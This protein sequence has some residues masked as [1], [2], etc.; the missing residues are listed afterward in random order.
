[1]PRPR[2][3]VSGLLA[4]WALVAGGSP[5]PSARA[6]ARVDFPGLVRSGF[7]F[8][9]APFPECHASTIA[10]T[11]GGLV[12]AWFG[13]TAEGNPDVGIWLARLDGN[14]WSSP[15]A[16]ARGEADGN[17]SPCWNPVLFQPVG[18]PLLLFYKVGP[19]P[20]DWWGMVTTSDDGGQTWAAP[21]RLPDGI[22]GPIKNKPIARPDDAILC[23]SSTEDQGWRVHFETTRDLGR[24][25]TRTPPVAGNGFNAIQPSILTHGD[26]TLQALCRTREQRLVTTWSTDGG[27]T[28]SALRATTLPNPNSGTDA[29]TLADGRQLLVYNHT[30][31]GRSPLN[32]AIAADGRDWQAALVLEDEP[33]EYSYPAVIQTAD[34]LVQI[35][36]TW[37]RRR[38]RHVVVDP[39]RLVPQPIVDGRWPP[40]LNRR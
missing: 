21:R 32:L 3:L 20:R 10:A 19:S 12:A 40:S 9:A 5:T 25:W 6:G 13:G 14:A 28:W 36:Y 23:P 39:A 22:L 15:V 38:I 24:T 18:G 2:T 8:E 37:N 11:P 30:A 4:C 17:R 27:A 33:G 7:I 35:T 1:M 16:V 26:G 29:V 34:G 31:R